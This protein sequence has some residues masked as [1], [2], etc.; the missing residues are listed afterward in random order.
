MPESDT[1]SLVIKR[2]DF[3]AELAEGPLE[4]RELVDALAYS[5]AT[6]NRAIAALEAAGLVRDTPAGCETTLAATLALETYREFVE[7]ER[8]ILDARSVLAPLA[9]DAAISSELL[10]DGDRYPVEAAG[11]YENFERVR[12]SI[13]DA[14]VVDVLVP[15][16][17]ALPALDHW[18]NA[19][20]AAEDATVVLADCISESVRRDHRT[21]S[22]LTDQ[23]VDVRSGDAPPF[24]LVRTSDD[25]ARAAFVLVYDDDAPG[26]GAVRNDSSAAVDW[27]SDL[28]RSSRADA[29]R[30]GEAV[31]TDDAP[32]ADATRRRRTTDALPRVLE[33]E[34]FVALTDAYFQSH[35]PR[36]LATALR[37]GLTLADVRNGLAIERSAS[38]AATS[39]TVTESLLSRLGAGEDCAV[40]GQPGAGKST[41]CKAVAC[42]WYD[43]GRGPVL[44]RESGQ[45]EPFESVASLRAYLREV[46]GEALVVVEDAVRPEANAVLEV[47]AEYACVDDVRFL[48]DARGSDWGET[49]LLPVDAAV[50]EYK[51]AGPSV[52]TLSPPDATECARLLER[53]EAETGRSIDATAEEL[54]ERTHDAT[55]VSGGMFLLAHHVCLHADPLSS[56][57]SVTPTPLV[58]DVQERLAELKTE[59][60]DVAVGA[61]LLTQFLNVA[62]HPVHEEFLQAQTVGVPDLTT[63]AVRSV[64]TDGQLVVDDGHEGLRTPHDQWSRVFLTEALEVLVDAP[65]RLGAALSNVLDLTDGDTRSALDALTRN[66]PV[67][68]RIAAAPTAWADDLVAQLFEAGEDRLELSPYYGT[69]ETPTFDLQAVCSD[70]TV[71]EC[72]YSRG[73]RRSEAGDLEAAAATYQ[74]VV[75]AI[76][77]HDDPERFAATKANCI[78]GIGSMRGRQ[79]DVETYEELARTALDLHRE[80][81]TEHG[82]ASCYLGL[83]HAAKRRSD[84]E[85]AAEYA[86]RGASIFDD[87]GDLQRKARCLGNVAVAALTVDDYET[88]EEYAARSTDIRRTIGTEYGLS[89]SHML[90][91]RI[92]EGRGRYDDAM[93]HHRRG[94]VAADSLGTD[95]WRVVSLN[96]MANVAMKRGRLDEAESLFDRASAHTRS[97]G[98][99]R[100]DAIIDET[101]AEVWRRRGDLETAREHATEGLSHARDAGDD[102]LEATVRVRLGQLA[103]DRGATET[104][105]SE[106][107]SALETFEALDRDTWRLRAVLHLARLEL[108]AGAVERAAEY[109]S[110]ANDL[111]DADAD[112]ATAAWLQ[113]VRGEIRAMRGD[114]AGARDCFEAAESMVDDVADTYVRAVVHSQL[115]TFASS[116]G[117]GGAAVE[118]LEAAADLAESIGADRV[119]REAA[120]DAETEDAPVSAED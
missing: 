16:T 2:A 61:A 84:H 86:R 39:G 103:L 28:V 37:T 14:G 96:N 68:R 117:D 71:F 115:G 98:D 116:Q 7:A 105:R 29:E 60:S 87:L 32:S 81:G 31:E 53:Y 34:G 66:S 6:V 10:R 91:G 113:C 33:A 89:H 95:E 76:D 52:T 79:G 49:R 63:D 26:F 51:N 15:S 106:L 62:E 41:V 83:G 40:V 72:G 78:L 82:V 48:V 90:L 88:A 74:A 56:V 85:Q 1:L 12:E 38:D 23:G 109:A 35:E 93:D 100:Y 19:L 120:A 65:E 77:E 102:Y 8:D 110:T 55:S 92:A 118:H 25:D 58:E 94:L 112:V 73:Q 80:H 59:A 47:A 119:Q 20:V 111:V 108:D 18:Q 17:R 36:D 30:F 54:V 11:T 27:A 64:L 13:V 75:D 104:G 46:D 5:R 97:V 24:L 21:L 50:R 57:D 4:K 101:L 45:R 67:L 70:E 44:Y 114:G 99:P 69:F 43:R 9:H 107:E 42:E 3:L 22:W